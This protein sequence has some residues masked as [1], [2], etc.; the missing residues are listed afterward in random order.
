M[1]TRCTMEYRGPKV[2][3]STACRVCHRVIDLPTGKLKVGFIWRGD[4]KC[5]AQVWLKILSH[6]AWIPELTGSVEI[7][8]F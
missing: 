4:C 8:N 2:G 3:I 7:N 1:I 5:G 6:D